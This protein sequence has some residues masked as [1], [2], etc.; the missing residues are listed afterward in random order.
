MAPARVPPSTMTES[1]SMDQAAQVHDAT[2]R[3]DATNPPQH[4][5]VNV[6]ETT[7][8][9]VVVAPLPAVQPADVTITIDRGQV[10]IKAAV[11]SAGPREYLVQEWSYGGYERTLELPDGY[12]GEA[13]ASLANGQ[14]ALRVLKGPAEGRRTITPA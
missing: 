13:T 6:Y 4:V 5:P 14:L 10:T 7:D 11:R 3:A 12:G 2:E 9:V 8:A 1:S